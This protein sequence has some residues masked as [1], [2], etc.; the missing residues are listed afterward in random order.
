MFVSFYMY[1]TCEFRLIILNLNGN[2]FNL[3]W[4]IYYPLI[5]RASMPA[6]E[7]KY[8]FFV[9]PKNYKRFGG[10]LLLVSGIK[11]KL[12]HFFKIKVPSRPHPIK[13]MIGIGCWQFLETKIPLTERGNK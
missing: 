13:K 8:N 10:S 5:R 4:V 11:K 1:D 9:G 7:K 12:D 2:Y 6:F 3:R